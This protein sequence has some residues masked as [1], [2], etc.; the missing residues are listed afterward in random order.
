MKKFCR[1]HYLSIRRMREW[2]DVYDQLK[3]ILDEQG[4][5]IRKRR[6]AA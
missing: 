1:E 2:I 3:A 6:E 4:W 5:K